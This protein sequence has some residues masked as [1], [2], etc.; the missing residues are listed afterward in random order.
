[1][2]ENN[3]QEKEFMLTHDFQGNKDA[4]KHWVSPAQLNALL[5]AKYPHEQDLIDMHIQETK[6]KEL[7]Y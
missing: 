4:S 1:M 2:N 5:D 6:D 7:T 3:E